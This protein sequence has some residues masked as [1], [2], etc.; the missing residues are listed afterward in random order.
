MSHKKCGSVIDCLE[1]LL[2]NIYATYSLAQLFHWN[3]TG[4][5]FKSLHELFEEIY[6]DLAVRLDDSAERIRALGDKIPRDFK[7]RALFF[8]W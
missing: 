5:N 3:V 6:T 2:A 7:D 8:Y 4:P 1:N